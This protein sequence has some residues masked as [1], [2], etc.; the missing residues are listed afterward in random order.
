MEQEQSQQEPSQEQL[1]L[2]KSFI[3]VLVEEGNKD[4]QEIQKIREQLKLLE[5]QGG[6]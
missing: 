5:K 4:R 2:L 1:N 3:D 6:D